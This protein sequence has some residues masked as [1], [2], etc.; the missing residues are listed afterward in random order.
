MQSCFSFGTPSL[1]TGSM[2]PAAVSYE[3][4][5]NEERAKSA[6]I[7]ARV[8]ARCNELL[9]QLGAYQRMER[10]QSAW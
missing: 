4:E 2:H 6:A 8:Q 3:A 10:L 9:R 1:L 7:E 5:L